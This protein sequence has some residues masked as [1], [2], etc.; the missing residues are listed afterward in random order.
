MP[1]KFNIFLTIFSALLLFSCDSDLEN[2]GYVTKFSDFKRVRDGETTKDEV[3]AMLG[4]PTTKSVYGKEQWIYAGIEE[5][6]ETFFEPEVKNFQAYIITFNDE[7][8]VSRVESKGKDSLREFEV[9][10]DKTL[11]GGSEMTVMQQLLGNLGKFN[12]MG[13]R[14]A[15]S[16][17]IPGQ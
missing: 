8:I 12:P 14:G 11:T 10:D 15:G 7:G 2:R 3:Q 13:N 5:T 6:Q 4:S 16:R 9:S 1:H 17:G